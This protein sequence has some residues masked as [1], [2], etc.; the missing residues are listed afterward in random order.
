MDAPS[1]HETFTSALSVLAACL[2]KM[3]ATSFSPFYFASVPIRAIQMSR[4]SPSS[5]A[6]LTLRI[7]FF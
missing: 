1:L 3:Y 5:V 4:V 7:S 6:S 2:A